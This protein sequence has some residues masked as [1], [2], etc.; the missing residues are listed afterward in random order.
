MVLNAIDAAE[1]GAEILPRTRLTAARRQGGL[2]RATLEPN[3]PG[4]GPGSG[5][6]GGDGG[7]RDCCWRFGPVAGDG[8]STLADA[9]QDNAD[10]NIL[11]FRYE[12]LGKDAAFGRIDLEG[13]LVGL[14]LHHR[15]IPSD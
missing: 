11:A 13:N 7:G 15:L 6:G 8:G 5:P 3:D 10:T 2:W 12:N 4:G 1:R 9:P 14:Q